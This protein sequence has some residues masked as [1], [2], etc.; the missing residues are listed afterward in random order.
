MD[1]TPIQI[2]V[3]VLEHHDIPSCV[4]GEMALNYYSVPRVYHLSDD[5][6]KFNN[7]TEYKCGHPHMRTTRW[8]HPR[9]TL[10]IFPAD[11]FHLQPINETIAQSRAANEPR[12]HISKE[13]QLDPECIAN[14][15]W[16][17]PPVFLSGLAKRWLDFADD[18]AMMAVEQ[19]VDGMNL[20]ETWAKT[21]LQ[22]GPEFTLIMAQIDDKSGRIDYFSGNKVTCLIKD[23][24]EAAN[25]KLI[26]GYE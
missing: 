13:L 21:N 11:L 15:P 14:I 20:D 16:P 8:A 1:A 5:V 7:Y 6:A 3:R 26:P 23:E 18:T 2:E 4:I 22:D 25:V 12:I 9:Q 17:R 19:L 24:K 10:V